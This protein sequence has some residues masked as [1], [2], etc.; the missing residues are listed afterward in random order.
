[1]A[2]LSKRSHKLINLYYN[3]TIHSFA[4]YEDD[5][6]MAFSLD[7]DD[8]KIIVF[9]NEALVGIDYLLLQKAQDS[10]EKSNLDSLVNY[11]KDN[12]I[13]KYPEIYI[14]YV[15]GG[16]LTKNKLID[17][18][19]DLNKIRR[20]RDNYE[21]RIVNQAPYKENNLLNKIIQV[22]TPFM[23]V[24]LLERMPLY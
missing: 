10:I 14:K 21:Y 6:P 8:D 11:I 20:N 22:A 19:I 5:P 13:E 2:Y 1:M 15:A 24:P 7:N 3:E 16:R 12:Q 18:Y 23:S 4:S 17:K 9:D